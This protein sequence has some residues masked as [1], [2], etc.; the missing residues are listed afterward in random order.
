MPTDTVIKFDHV[1]KK[2]SLQNQ[3][4]FKEFLPALLKGE[5]TTTGFTALDNLSFEIHRGEVVGIIGPNGSGKSTILKLIAGVM[6]PSSGKVTVEGQVSPLIELGAGMHPELSGREN[7]Y[8][9]GAILGLKRKEIDKNLQDIIDFSEISEFIDQP[10]KHYSSGMYMRL[11]FSIAIHVH[12]EILL[13]DEILAVGDTDFQAKCFKKMNE[14]KKDNNIT[15]VFVS[16]NLN[17]VKTFCSRV[18]YL[19]HHQ[20]L[21]NGDPK[22]ITKIYKNDILINK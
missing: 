12:P 14:Y 11:A 2:F 19:N 1:T 10:V 22:E 7:I 4:T 21:A 15:I 17:Q 18:I 6:S 5:D 16:H 9:N 3:K 8:L 20:I 13:V